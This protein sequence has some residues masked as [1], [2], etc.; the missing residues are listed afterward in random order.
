MDSLIGGAGN[1][2]LDGG[3]GNDI[4]IGGTGND[5]YVLSSI[6]EIV[7][8]T[9]NGGNDTL[10]S[11]GYAKDLRLGKYANFEN[12]IYTHATTSAI[13]NGSAADNLLESRS[14]GDDKA[15]G[16]DGND[17]LIGGG[18]NDSLFGGEGDDSLVGGAGVDSLVGGNGDDV[19]SVD[20]GDL[21]TEVAN[22]G[23]DTLIGTKISLALTTEIESLFY[24]GS[25]AASL[26]GNALDNE[27][28]GGVAA[29]TITAGA[30]NDSLWRQ[31]CGRRLLDRGFGRRPAGVHQRSGRGYAD[32]RPG[33]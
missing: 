27:I 28:G 17:T 13:L 32:W 7:I 26:V 10:E 33:R 2:Y 21:V 5:T 14:A 12:I 29:D 30:G 18:G 22:G 4:M 15:Y 11:P 25:T 24:T 31:L 19:Y 23:T 6:F 3:V 8:E 20:A 1:D 9:A 16:W